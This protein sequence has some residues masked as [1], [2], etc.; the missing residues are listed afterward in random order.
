MTARSRPITHNIFRPCAAASYLWLAVLDPA[1][2][3]QTTVLQWSLGRTPRT[4]GFQVIDTLLNLLFRCAHRRLTSPLTPVSKKG[5]PRGDTYVVCLDCGKQFDYDLKE[6]RIGKPIDRSHDAS[7]VPEN[8]PVPSATK[9]KY[10]ALAA[11]PVAMVI[12]AILNTKKSDAKKK[13]RAEDEHSAGNPVAPAEGNP[14]PAEK[15]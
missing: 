2:R 4:W 5:V 11:V 10:A 9:V 7:V 15:K 3:R 14:G 13:A 12:G 6:M 1:G 8:L